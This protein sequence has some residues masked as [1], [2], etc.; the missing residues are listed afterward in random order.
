MATRRI[1]VSGTLPPPPEGALLYAALG[2]PNTT[3]DLYLLNPTD[4]SETSIGPIGFA[5][6]GLAFHP[7]SGV[8]YGVTNNNSASNPRSLIT[9]NT[10]TGAGTLVGSLGLATP[11]NDCAFDSAG[12]LY[13]FRQSTRTLYQINTATGTA[14][15]VASGPITG[16]SVFG[17]PVTGMG[18]DFDGSDVMV[19]VAREVSH[20]Y[21][22]VDEHTGAATEQVPLTDSPGD[23]DDDSINCLSFTAHAQLWGIDVAGNGFWLVRIS[24]LTGEISTVGQTLDFFDALAWDRRATMG[25]SYP[26][27][28]NV[29]PYV[30]YTLAP[31]TRLARKSHPF[32]RAP[33]IV[34][35]PP[36]PRDPEKVTIDVTLA[37]QPKTKTRSQLG[38]RYVVFPGAPVVPPVETVVRVH[39]AAF[40]SRLTERRRTMGGVRAPRAV[41]FV[42][43]FKTRVFLAALARNRRAAYLSYLS[44]PATLEPPIPIYIDKITVWVSATPRRM[45]RGGRL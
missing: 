17:D 32:L 22:T 5:M 43:T 41:R 2:G 33:Y 16:P 15:Q 21:Y 13:G 1:T 26:H 38:P 45:G 18:A 20:P 31:S 35:P 19:V 42:V 25:A 7:T 44:P 39:S 10:T 12:N 37:P 9:V 14:T 30:D 27:Q 36:P 29:K 23:F 8:L 40:A 24:T 4:A 6:T 34:Y 28:P 3:S 11:I